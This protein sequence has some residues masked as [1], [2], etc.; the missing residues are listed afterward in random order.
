MKAAVV[1][2]VLK[3]DPAAVM[4]ATGNLLV[5]PFTEAKAKEV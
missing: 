4:P 5:A 3:S 2:A 1:P